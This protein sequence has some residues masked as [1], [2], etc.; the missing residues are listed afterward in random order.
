MITSV[1]HL[2]QSRLFLI[3]LIFTEIRVLSA[4]AELSP[5]YISGLCPRALR[6]SHQVTSEPSIVHSELKRGVNVL[7]IIS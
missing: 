7:D 2:I 4:S 1:N 6:V 5:L 3:N